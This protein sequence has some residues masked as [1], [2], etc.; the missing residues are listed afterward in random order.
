MGKY[1]KACHS[2]TEGYAPLAT[3]ESLAAIPLY[4]TLWPPN[5]AAVDVTVTFSKVD[6]TFKTIPH[7]LH[8]NPRNI[9]HLLM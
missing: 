1:M 7:L 3:M 6:V 4:L 9:F 2:V 8:P 5:L